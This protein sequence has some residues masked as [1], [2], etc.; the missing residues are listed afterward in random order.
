M[1]L[2]NTEQGM[3]FSLVIVMVIG[4]VMVIVTGVV[5]LM[6]R[7]LAIFSSYIVNLFEQGCQSL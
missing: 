4:M 5:I 2:E 3:S 1:C 6:V 7:K